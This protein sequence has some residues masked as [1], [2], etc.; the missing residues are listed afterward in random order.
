M[1]EKMHIEEKIFNGAVVG[2]A[3][4]TKECKIMCYRATMGI[5][6]P[7]GTGTSFPAP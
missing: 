1:H 5:H 3:A 4:K 7:L 2:V 6:A